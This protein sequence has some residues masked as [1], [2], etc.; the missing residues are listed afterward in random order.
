MSCPL[1][2]ITSIDLKFTHQPHYRAGGVDIMEVL[3]SKMTDEMYKGLAV[4]DALRYLTRYLENN[5]LDDAEKALTML[6]WMIYRM[7]IN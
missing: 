4:G 1:E 6:A 7:R 5:N 3:Q 2:K